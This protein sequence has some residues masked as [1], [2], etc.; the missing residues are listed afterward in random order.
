M[1]LHQ[2]IYFS[3]NTVAGDDRALLQHLREII[4][5]S[6][7]NNQ[8]DGITGYLVFDKTW[9][10]Q[11]L[12]G[13][14]NQIFSTYRRIEGDPRHA[15]VTLVQT[16]EVLQRS[17][18]SW[19]MGG[20]MR[21]PEKQEIYLRYGIGS[22]IDPKKLTGGDILGLAVDLQNLEQAQKSAQ[23]MAG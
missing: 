6:Q 2:L 17:F 10:L 7:R 3:R 5:V 20:S 23:R 12:E 8:R 1:K 9:F 18:P 4:A 13:E 21:T 19:T 11:I 22:Q 15:Q 14:R 16:R